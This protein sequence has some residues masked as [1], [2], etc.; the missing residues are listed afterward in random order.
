MHSH[1]DAELI[2]QKALFLYL[3]KVGAT[4]AV[5]AQMAINKLVAVA[6]QAVETVADHEASIDMLDSV[7]ASAQ[8]KHRA[9]AVGL[10]AT[11]G[12]VVMPTPPGMQ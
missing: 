7:K 2:A 12:V 4:S 8:M 6:T 10:C 3:N 5:D 1:K 11:S 9:S